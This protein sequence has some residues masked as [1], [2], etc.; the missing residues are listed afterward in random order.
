[1]RTPSTLQL[2]IMN[3]SSPEI[4]SFSSSVTRVAETVDTSSGREGKHFS[5]LKCMLN[6]RSSVL[7]LSLPSLSSSFLPLPA[8]LLAL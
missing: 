5:I 8:C 3:Y 1:M 6:S 4:E 7:T 2:C